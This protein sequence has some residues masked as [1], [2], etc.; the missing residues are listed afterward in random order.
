MTLSLVVLFRICLL[1]KGNKRNK[2]MELN[3]TEK[4]LHKNDTINPM[5][6]QLT[7]WQYIFTNDIFDKGLRDKIYK[8][9]I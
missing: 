8:E 2:P 5:K 9:L 1:S 7:E 3:Q 4:F 6:R